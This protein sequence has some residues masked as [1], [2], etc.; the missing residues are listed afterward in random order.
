M[1][2]R[3]GRGLNALINSGP[4]TKDRYTSVSVVKI[5]Y[6]K[7]NRYQPR[8]SF[9]E[10]KLKDL[11]ASLKES[12]LIQPLIVTKKE[13]DTFELIAG[14]RRLQAAKIAGITEVPVIIK[15]VT[16]KEQLQFAIIENVQRE[17]LNPIDEAKAYQQ[18]NSEFELTHGEISKII[19]KDRATITNS[20]R[21]LKLSNNI[22]EMI[23]NDKIKPGHA[24]AILQVPESERENFAQSVSKRKYSVRKA[25]Q[26][27]KK[28][29]EPN[30]KKKQAEILAE[31]RNKMDKISKELT[32][33]YGIKVN[34][35]G[36]TRKGKIVFNYKSKAELNYILEK[37]KDE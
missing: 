14:E 21:L 8:K 3:L 35:Q 24:R 37:L 15:K 7:P 12:G 36:K 30:P 25:E 19:G 26:M 34:L 4:E 17:D 16:E 28:Y 6:I 13:D 2:T 5:D 29:S 1:T 11:A 18:L 10:E 20:L 33:K 32:Q 22:Q 27:A 31:E 9:N 23:L